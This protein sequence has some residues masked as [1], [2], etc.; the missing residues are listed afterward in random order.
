MTKMNLMNRQLKHI[1]RP[2][3]IIG[4]PII[5]FKILFGVKN[6]GK[7]LLSYI[8]LRNQPTNY[9]LKNGLKI[10]TNSGIDA[11][12]ILVT[13]L[14]N[15]YGLPKNNS[16]I[17]DIGANIGTYSLNCARNLS[18][19]RIYAFEPEDK[20]YQL[21][22]K[23]IKVN[24]F[25]KKIFTE[26]IAIY[27]KK[28]KANLLISDQSPFHSLKHINHCK[29]H[30]VS[31]ESLNYVF[32]KYKIKCCDLLKI[33]CEGSEFA[34]IKNISQTNLIKIKEIRMEY[35]NQNK[36]ENVD[37]LVKYLGKYGFRQKRRI[38][39]SDKLGNIWFENLT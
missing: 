32:G 17:I 18:K 7:F 3:N 20:N 29:T 27:D 12:T 15:E 19:C 21:L 24:R 6:P 36:K 39:N 23:N 38:T 28:G 22:A 5:I 10:F 9:Q 8:G 37:A 35:H 33:D 14:N 1:L 2:K 31:K 16:T 34:I 30:T 26:K 13:I 4:Y 11:V 25:Q